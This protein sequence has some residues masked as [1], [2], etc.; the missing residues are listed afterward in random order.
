MARVAEFLGAPLASVPLPMGATSA[1]PGIHVVIV[2]DNM[3]YRRM[4]HEVLQVARRCRAGYAQLY[5]PIDVVAAVARNLERTQGRVHDKT[6]L[7]MAG[8]LEPPDPSRFPWEHNT[9]VILAGSAVADNILDETVAKAVFSAVTAAAAAASAAGDLPAAPSIDG[10]GAGGG[11]DGGSGGENAAVLRVATGASRLHSAD[12]RLRQRVARLVGE[13]E[14]YRCRG[15]SGGD[16]GKGGSNGSGGSRGGKGDKGRDCGGEISRSGHG[17]SGGG[18]GSSL[19]IS[20]T[21]VV[22]NSRSFGSLRG[23]E[24]RAVKS[25]IDATVVLRLERRVLARACAAAK[26][27]V[28]ED[29]RASGG[30]APVPVGG[31]TAVAAAASVDA[32]ANGSGDRGEGEDDDSKEATL[33][34]AALRGTLQAELAASD[35]DGEVAV[36]VAAF[37]STSPLFACCGDEA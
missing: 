3:Q 19:G 37:I 12:Q 29:L 16:E 27:L 7:K 8:N 9:A 18:D 31:A 6:I 4:R 13:Y 30:S 23:R 28:L 2:D 10:A 26:Q 21:A 25:E 14:S 32:G 15:W 20:L 5:F 34:A 22:E 24:G 35:A 17:G 11:G 33:F 36:R 1:F